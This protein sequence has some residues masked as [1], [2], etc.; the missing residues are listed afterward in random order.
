[1]LLSQNNS[2]IILTDAVSIKFAE[3]MLNVDSLPIELL[4]VGN[5]AL[6]AAIRDDLSILFAVLSVSYQTYPGNFLA[7]DQMWI[8]HHKK[9][10]QHTTAHTEM[11]SR[12]LNWTSIITQFGYQEAQFEKVLNG[13]KY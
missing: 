10:N 1:M 8:D 4:Q 3:C 12:F 6:W 2:N 5:Q 9:S 13:W 11:H 7:M